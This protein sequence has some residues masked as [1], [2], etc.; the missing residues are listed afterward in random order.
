[1]T[2]PV[3]E[4]DG[5]TAGYGDV[6][7]VRNLD[8]TVGAGEVVAL[9]G[10]NGGGKTTTL[11]TISGLI[12]P[13]RGSIRFLGAPVDRRP[14]RLSRSGLAHVPDDRGLFG[15][16]TVRDH[17]D[18]SGRRR[19]RDPVRGQVLEWFPALTPLLDRTA[20]VLSGGEQ[21][22][23]AL[24]QA[25]VRE[26]KVL[27]VDELSMG[28]S[29]IVVGSILPVIRQVAS[30]SGC[31]VLLVEQHATMALEVADRGY[32]LSHGDLVVE[33]SATDLARDWDQ[34]QAGY[35]GS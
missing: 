5:L 17:L 29:P 21:Q 16:L 27:M 4:V 3:L 33:G 25:L 28:L 19:R 18:L 14:H 24:A 26:P 11:L 35:I 7:V 12:A 13:M 34:L 31:G 6:A 9:L 10:P 30:E 2:N 20:G 23:L 32:L 22:M 15:G 1:V 8:L